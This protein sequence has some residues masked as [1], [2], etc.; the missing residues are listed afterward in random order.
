[1]WRNLSYR[2]KIPLSLSAVILLTVIIVSASLV[3]QGY[4]EAKQE[5]I[6]NALS[7]GRVLART[8]R[9]ALLHDQVWLA[10]EAIATPFDAQGKTSASEPR[11]TVLDLS[12]AIYVSTQ[13]QRYPMTVSL[14]SLGGIYGGL[15]DKINALRGGTS[16]TVED[17]DPAQ[18][19][20]LLPI[21]SDDGARLGTLMMEYPRALLLPRFYKTIEGVGY[22]TLGVLLVLLPIGWFAGKRMAEPLSELADALSR[23]GHE[24]P[25]A[26][27]FQAQPGRDEIGQLRAT[28]HAMLKELKDKEALERQ[29]IASD[30][31]AAIGRLTAG[32][33]HEINN[34]LGGM[35]NA[36]NT[37]KRHGHPDELATRTMSLLERG[38]VQV[39]DTVQ[40]L[41]VEARLES[42]A[43]T[44]DDIEDVRTLITPEVEKKSARL[45]W[46]HNL[47]EPVPLPSTQVR[48]ILINLLLNAADAVKERGR[49]ECRIANDGAMLRVGVKNDGAHIA[50]ERIEHLFEPFANGDGSGNGLGLWM[51]YQLVR[52]LSG[53]IEVE[54]QPEVTTFSVS[55]P[56]G[57]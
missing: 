26:I 16:V 45:E 38:L 23:V 53:K 46:V 3:V 5:L 41:L 24:A 40:A 10:Y 27:V 18:L 48:Q 4:Q 49:V 55:L 15:G 44:A 52:Q 57:A 8:L 34:P 25:N 33:A 31:L 7:L 42:H 51:T 22:S 30:R 36:V 54:S 39:K 47:S 20:L 29:M 17:L 11:I 37:Y 2:Y 21:V 19:L 28:F 56:L 1:V 13:P 35:L 32:I 12:E 9:P 14:A 43:L 50:P 6:A